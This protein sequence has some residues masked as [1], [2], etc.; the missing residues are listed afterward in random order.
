MPTY[1]GS[2]HC[3][4]VS[5]SFHGPEI[6]RALKCNCSICLRKGTPMSAFTIAPEEIKIDASGETLSL[7]QF[8]TR[9]AKHYFC[10]RCG[11]YTFHETVR[12]P[13]HFRVNLGCVTRCSPLELPIEVFDGAAL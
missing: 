11:I 10:N 3:G 4:A 13:G 7:Y 5:F 12:R 1:S 9:V 6:D 8:G 2:S